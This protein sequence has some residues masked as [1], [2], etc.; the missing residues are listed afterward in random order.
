MEEALILAG[1]DPVKLLESFKSAFSSGSNALKLFYEDEAGFEAGKEEVL[2]FVYIYVYVYK[3]MKCY[4]SY[5]M[6][7]LV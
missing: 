7:S 5:N 3:C 4:I 6:L 1:E 2:Y